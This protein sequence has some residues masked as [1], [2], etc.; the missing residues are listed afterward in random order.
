M[1]FSVHLLLP[2]FFMLFYFPAPMASCS[3]SVSLQ[4]PTESFS[5]FANHLDCYEFLHPAWEWLHLIVENPEAIADLSSAQAYDVLVEQCALMVYA[6]AVLVLIPPLLVPDDIK[7]FWQYHHLIYQRLNTFAHNWLGNPDWITNLGVL[8]LDM[9]SKFPPADPNSIPLTNEILAKARALHA[10]ELAREEANC[11]DASTPSRDPSPFHPVCVAKC[12]AIATSGEG[13][14]VKKAK[15]VHN[16]TKA[17]TPALLLEAMESIHHHLPPKIHSWE[18][19]P[20]ITTKQ[21]SIWHAE[22]A[23]PI[24]TICIQCR[25]TMTAHLTSPVGLVIIVMEPVAPLFLFLRSTLISGRSV[26]QW[27]STPYQAEEVG[28]HAQSIA[29]QALALVKDIVEEDFEGQPSMLFFLRRVPCFGSVE[30]NVKYIMDIMLSLNNCLKA[31]IKYIGTLRKSVLGDGRM[32]GWVMSKG[33]GSRMHGHWFE[34]QIQMMASVLRAAK[35]L[36]IM[37]V[38]GTKGMRLNRVLVESE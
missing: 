16:N 2:L 27:A 38:W 21:A 10:A 9:S 23:G 31:F 33:V 1:T 15:M 24:C 6:Y 4:A 18:V 28:N 13:E 5:N 11:L 19:V 14:K 34:S 26:I 36:Q 8:P 30:V 7:A 35:W 32:Y 29:D 3:T 12:K 37:A 20:W 22:V 25:F 17:K